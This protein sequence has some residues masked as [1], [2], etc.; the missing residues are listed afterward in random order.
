MGYRR[1][2]SK[3]KKSSIKALIERLDHGT[4]VSRRRLLRTIGITA[5]K[6]MDREWRKELVS[7]AEKPPE[8]VRYSKKLGIALRK[9]GL[10][11]LYSSRHSPKATKLSH[12][13]DSAFEDALQYLTD[14]LYGKP[15]LQMWLDRDLRPSDPDFGLHPE[16]MPYP[17]WSKSRNAR[18]GGI[19]KRTIRDLKREA[20]EEAL[21]RLERRGKPPELPTFELP[22][23]LLSRDRKTRRNH[24]YSDWKF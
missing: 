10:A 11:D 15:E 3:M 17:V 8:I 13:A 21:E 20:L 23:I 24:D 16:G 7:R 18:G 6:K 4:D 5:V 9:Y 19:P 22:S 12:A 14:V 2:G 1:C